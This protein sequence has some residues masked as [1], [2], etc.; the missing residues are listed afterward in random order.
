MGKFVV[1]I[2][3]GGTSARAALV[4]LES[5]EII[6]ERTTNS[7]DDGQK[8]VQILCSLVKDL[9]RSSKT[10]VSSVGIGIAGLAHKSGI[11]RY[12]PNLPNL[13]EFPHLPCKTLS[14]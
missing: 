9:E 10:N 3:I 6:Q 5:R 14:P 7:S 4:D 11:I 13:I 2:D 12:S 1:G 8:L